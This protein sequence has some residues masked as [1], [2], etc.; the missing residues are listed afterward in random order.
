MTYPEKYAVGPHEYMNLKIEYVMWYRWV[1]YGPS[2]PRLGRTGHANAQ[3][4]EWQAPPLDSVHKILLHRVEL[5]LS[6]FVS[7][8]RKK[9]QESA[10]CLVNSGNTSAIHNSPRLKFGAR[11]GPIDLYEN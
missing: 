2:L 4:C 7:E 3:V 5:S 9:G 6:K 10:S 11:G 1:F 8:H